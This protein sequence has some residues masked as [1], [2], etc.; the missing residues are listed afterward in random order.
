M[1]PAWI[2]F[3]TGE[4]FSSEIQDLVLLSVFIELGLESDEIDAPFCSSSKMSNITTFTF[5]SN[6]CHASESIQ[7]F[8]IN[9]LLTVLNSNAPAVKISAPPAGGGRRML[10][11]NIQKD[12]DIRLKCAGYTP[13]PK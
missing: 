8:R 1:N 12:T 3:C 9:T 7:R 10:I 13:I 5:K 11:S 4:Y 6:I 2:S